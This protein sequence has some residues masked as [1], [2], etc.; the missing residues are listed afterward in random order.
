MKV[1]TVELSVDLCNTVMGV[2]DSLSKAQ[3]EFNRK[4]KNRLQELEY[5]VDS[6]NRELTEDELKPHYEICEYELQ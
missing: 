3:E 1:Y 2:Y 5:W 4:E 6:R